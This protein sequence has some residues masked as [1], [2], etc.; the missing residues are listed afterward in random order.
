M[1]KYLIVSLLLVSAML[2][3]QVTIQPGIRGGAN[4]SK[5]N[6]VKSDGKT[7]FYLGASISLNLSKFYTLQPEVTYTRQ[8][9]EN[10]YKRENTYN[11]DTGQYEYVETYKDFDLAYLSVG[12]VNKF[13]V[14]PGRDFHLLIAPSFDILVEENNEYN[15]GSAGYYVENDDVTDIDLTATLGAGYDFPFGLGIEARYKMGVVNVID[16]AFSS[17][18][19]R[20]RVF[21]VGV[22]YKFFSKK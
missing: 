18:S 4:F 17:A 7:D 21:Q 10:I 20:N 16:G 12:V 11:P 1:R 3:S 5:I 13:Y 6:G 15:L 2:S 14:T 22:N 8:G 9:G 19:T